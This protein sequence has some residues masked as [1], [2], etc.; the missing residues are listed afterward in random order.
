MKAKAFLLLMMAGTAQAETL[1]E[2]GRQCA[3]QIGEIPAMSFVVTD[4]AVRWR[5]LLSILWTSAKAPNV[6]CHRA[7][8][9][10]SQPSSSMFR[11]EQPQRRL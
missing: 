6:A 4:S 11:G 9:V 8:V 3:A 7:D 2:Y 5:L 1:F 10:R